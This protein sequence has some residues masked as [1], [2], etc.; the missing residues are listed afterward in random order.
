MRNSLTGLGHL[1]TCR[2]NTSTTMGRLE[3]A[4]GREEGLEGPDF[5]LFGQR[6]GTAVFRGSQPIS[7][8]RADPGVSKMFHRI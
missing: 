7:L 8:L 3:R 6:I 4:A 5:V 1:I 2:Q